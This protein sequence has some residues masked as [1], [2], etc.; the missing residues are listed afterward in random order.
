MALDANRLANEAQSRLLIMQPSRPLEGDFTKHLTVA[1][2]LMAERICYDPALFELRWLTLHGY[3]L[4]LVGET[5]DLNAPGT[6]INDPE[7]MLI[8]RR[9][10]FPS[11][12]VGTEN[13]RARFVAD[14][15]ALDDLP[16]DD[17]E[18][19]YTVVALTMYIEGSFT[20]TGFVN[21]SA[22]CIPL[23]ENI[24]EQLEPMLIDILVEVAIGQV[25]DL[26]ARADSGTTKVTAA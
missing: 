12:I 13:R 20:T 16:M 19:Y 8:P 18:V 9:R 2:K 10:G 23:L 26:K 14:Q 3:V 15:A 5:V 21:M 11:V 1:R 25:T 17:G 6:G 7:P 24:P 22:N 4:P